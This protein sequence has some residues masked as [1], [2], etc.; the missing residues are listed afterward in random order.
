MM[1]HQWGLVFGCAA[2]AYA[3]AFVVCMVLIGVKAYKEPGR[4]AYAIFPNRVECREGMWVNRRPTLRFDQV[5]GVEMEEG[6]LQRARGAGT[7][8]IISR[9]SRLNLA[10]VP[11]PKEVYDLIRSLALGDG[12]A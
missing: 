12:R 1:I 4:T 7:V 2:A 10:N 5:S 8:T 3:L 11:H 6:V 9:Q